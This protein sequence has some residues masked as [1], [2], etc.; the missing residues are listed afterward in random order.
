[1]TAFWKHS[2]F[3]PGNASVKGY[4]LLHIKEKTPFRIK[5]KVR[6]DVLSHLCTSKAMV[7]QYDRVAV[8]M[9]LIVDL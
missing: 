3:P 7:K 6:I 8:S 2:Q 4:T 5:D 1:M 9:N